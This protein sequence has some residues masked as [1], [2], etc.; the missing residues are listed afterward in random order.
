MFDSFLIGLPVT[1]VPTPALIVDADILEENIFYMA[2]FIK[3]SGV[4]LRPHVKTHKTPAIAHMQIRAGAV[5]VCCA[6]I[7]EAESMVYSGIYNVYI[8]NEISEPSKIRRLVNLAR[9]ADIIV[10][11]D[12]GKNVKDLSEA[13]VK[14]NAQLGIFIDVDVGMGRCGLRKI[15]DSVSVARKITDLPGVNLK[16]L[17]GYEGH[18]VF[19]EDR[20]ERENAGKKANMYLV[21]TAEIIRSSGI[22]VDIVSAAGT[23]TFDIASQV[24]GINEIEAGSYVFMDTHYAKLDL[25]FKQSL[26]VLTTAVSCPGDGVVIFDAGLKAISHERSLPVVEGNNTITIKQMAEEH[27]LGGFPEEAITIRAGDK[28][29]LIPSHCCTTIN[30]YDK[31]VSARNGCVEAVWPISGR[32]A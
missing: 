2:E 5:G 9:Q 28:V 14:N 32:R 11:V 1:E 19:I 7:G 27:A 24:A 4:N 16:G 13:A 17:M 6:T 31:L 30:L 23:G 22:D 29:H 12:D 18:A 15:S 25:P 26:K 10:A 3:K 21:K 8:A 20:N